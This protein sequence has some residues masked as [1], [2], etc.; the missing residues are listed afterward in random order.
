MPRILQSL[1]E[2]W[3]GFYSHLM[4]GLPF[5]DKFRG[6]EGY[7]ARKRVQASNGDALGGLEDG[8]CG[9]EI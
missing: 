8:E 9:I 5:F 6:A 7:V 3:N 4:L 1:V 2:W